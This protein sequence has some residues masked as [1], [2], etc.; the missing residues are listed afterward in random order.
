MPVQVRPPMQ[1][2]AGSSSEEP[3]LL[4][5]VIVLWGSMY[6]LVVWHQGSGP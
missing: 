4:L 5:G 6:T 2:M 3:A 1:A